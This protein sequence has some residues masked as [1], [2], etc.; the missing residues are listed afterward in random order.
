VAAN[1]E[2]VGR[3]HLPPAPW[4]SFHWGSDVG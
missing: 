3:R 1:C 4:E 2:V